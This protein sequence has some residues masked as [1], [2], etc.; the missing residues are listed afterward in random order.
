MKILKYRMQ[1]MTTEIEKTFFDTFELTYESCTDIFLN[2]CKF[3]CNECPYR[4]E[5]YPEITD[6]ILLEIEDIIHNE[7]NILIYEK[8][9]YSIRI[10]AHLM[11]DNLGC[12]S[13][14]YRVQAEAETKKEALLVLAMDINVKDTI[15]HQVQALFKEVNYATKS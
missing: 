14:Y 3:E 6:R 8:F 4:E 5:K 10:T 9:M 1:K 15:K 13:S 7:Y 12:D 2:P 11:D